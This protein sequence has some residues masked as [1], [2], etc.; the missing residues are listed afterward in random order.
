MPPA[1]RKLTWADLAPKLHRS[2]IGALNKL[3]VLWQAC[4]GHTEGTAG[5]TGALLALSALRRAEAPGITN[6]RE[7][8]PYV[9]AAVESWGARQGMAA[10]LPRQTAPAASLLPVRD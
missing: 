9:A 2:N 6:L 3:S 10:V 5:I 1:H 4:Y 7:V 8:N